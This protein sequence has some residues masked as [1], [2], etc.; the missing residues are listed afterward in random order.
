M[1]SLG[2]EFLLEEVP[3]WEWVMRVYILTSFPAQAFC[4]LCI[5]KKCN[6]PASCSYQTPGFSHHGKLYPSEL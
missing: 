6:K 4:F 5:D 1:E 3:L 2:E